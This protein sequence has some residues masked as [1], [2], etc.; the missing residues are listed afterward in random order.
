M[1]RR[2]AEANHVSVVCTATYLR[3]YEANEAH[4]KGLGATWEAVLT[5]QELYEGQAHNE[6]F[7]PVL[8]RK[9]SAADIPRPLRPFTHYRL[10]KNYEGLLRYIPTQPAVVPVP[11]GPKKVL[12]QTLRQVASTTRTQARPKPSATPLRR[13]RQQL[14]TRITRASRPQSDPPAVP[15]TSLWSSTPGTDPARAPQSP[16]PRPRGAE[17]RDRCDNDA[18]G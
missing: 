11:V 18:V 6:K 12:H 15:P 16:W 5:R 13:P 7:V 1:E 10:L 17:P 3:R 4:G 2:I 9:A 8:F 14:G